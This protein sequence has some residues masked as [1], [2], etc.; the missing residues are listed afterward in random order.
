MPAPFSAP[1]AAGNYPTRPVTMLSGRDRL[2]GGVRSMISRLPFAAG[3]LAALTGPLAGRAAEPS[4]AERGRE[5]L[6][7]RSYRPPTMTARAYQEVW[8]QWG[9]DRKPAPADYDRLFREI[10][11][12]SCRE[13]A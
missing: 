11:R 4:A 13:R 5:A 10:G 3:L 12:A 1:G 2:S 8:R 6:L 7:T 9:L